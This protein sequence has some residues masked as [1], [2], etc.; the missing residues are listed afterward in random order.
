MP[1]TSLKVMSIFGYTEEEIRFDTIKNNNYVK[2]NTKLKK[3]GIL[4]DKIN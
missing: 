4:F 3:I 2:K 1:E